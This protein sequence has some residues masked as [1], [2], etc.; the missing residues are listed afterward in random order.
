M[1]RQEI[2]IACHLSHDTAAQV[3]LGRSEIS[4]PSRST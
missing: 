3:N 4:K 2:E 1:L